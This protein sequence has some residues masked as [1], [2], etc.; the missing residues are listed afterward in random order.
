MIKPYERALNY[1]FKRGTHYRATMRRVLMLLDSSV[2]PRT[3]TTEYV[4]EILRE[5]L[6][7]E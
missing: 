5:A 2:D 1:W 7:E 3:N 6:T 4:R